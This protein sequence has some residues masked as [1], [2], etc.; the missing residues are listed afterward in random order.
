MMLFVAYFHLL[1]IKYNTIYGYWQHVYAAH[2]S[3]GYDCEYKEFE[4]L[5]YMLKGMK[6][7]L[8]DTA[9]APLLHISVEIL[10]RFGSELYTVS[11]TRL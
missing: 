4:T 9:P 3:L 11:R 1:P 10:R 8:G 2:V 6:R 7:V 5:K